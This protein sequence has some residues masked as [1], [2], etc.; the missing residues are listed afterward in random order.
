[1]RLIL[2]LVLFFALTGSLSAQERFR[3]KTVSHLYL[4]SY[5]VSTTEHHLQGSRGGLGV[6]HYYDPHWAWFL[7]VSRGTAI[8]TYT[9]EGGTAYYDLTASSYGYTGGM[10]WRTQLDR[11]GN[12]EPFVG[13]GLNIENYELVFEY[14]GS[15]I[16]TTNGTGFGPLFNLGARF[17]MGRNFVMIPSYEYSAI[18][19]KTSRGESSTLASNGFSLGLIVRF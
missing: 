15:K 17:A 6:K 18:T 13:L 10:E 19:Y 3:S 9:P 16:G 14:P 8:E 4:G 5:S 1:M 7:Q 2:S 11:E 12:M